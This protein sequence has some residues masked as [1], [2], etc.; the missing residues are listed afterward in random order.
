MAKG[1]PKGSVNKPKAQKIS[2]QLVSKNTRALAVDAADDI[3][4]DS[5]K[6]LAAWWSTHLSDKANSQ[7]KYV[8]SI[9]ALTKALDNEKSLVVLFTTKRK[10]MIDFL[11]GKLASLGNKQYALN[12][13]KTLINNL[14]KALN[15]F[16]PLRALADFEKIKEE[17]RLLSNT[18]QVTVIAEQKD[19]KKDYI[20]SIP[21][22]QAAIIN[23]F[24][25]NTE[26]RFI[27]EFYLWWALRDNLIRC[28][29]VSDVIETND[30]QYNYF[31][32]PPPNGSDYDP[33]FF[34]LNVYKTD[35][36]YG[37]QQRVLPIPLARQ[38]R[39]FC[40]REKKKYFSESREFVF[41]DQELSGK[42]TKIFKD[43][44]FPN[45]SINAIRKSMVTFVNETGSNQLIGQTAI[46]MGHDPNT[47]EFSYLRQSSDSN[48]RSSSNCDC[49]DDEKCCC[50]CCD[51]K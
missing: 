39:G 41:G 33:V 29:L 37:A 11:S 42:I 20:P 46:W 28:K 47:A 15:T 31:I 35:H 27:A 51:K 21:E 12:T 23:K 43:A 34:Q 49:E 16:P 14:I 18:L 17:L 45:M 7:K 19:K 3:D 32:M 13:R 22:L 30:K 24:Q 9:L 36:R 38:F 50:C 48:K 8:E 2:A 26:S 10:K 44:G 1:R 6:D 4:G 25:L 40:R 5:L